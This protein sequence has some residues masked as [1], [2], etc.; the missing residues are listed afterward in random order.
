M[1]VLH[2]YPSKIKF[3]EIIVRDYEFDR[4]CKNY[5]IFSNIVSEMK[6]IIG[7]NFK[8]YLVNVISANY[9][10]GD[11]T[12]T[13]TR[14]HVDGDFN[15]DNEYCIWCAGVN[16]TIFPVDAVEF[17]D[18]PSD[19][20]SQNIYL[21]K[22]L[23]NKKSFE[24]PNQTFVYYSSKDPHKGVNCKKPGSRVFIRLMG[25]NYIGAKNYV[26]I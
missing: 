5:R 22:V 7:G 10:T 4:F 1:E 12:C 25:T 15:S 8:N 18:F 23:K 3:P 20:N 16:R 9:K 14:Y 6:N 2:K 19:R 21:E 17:E 13:D 26:K 24:I 11:R